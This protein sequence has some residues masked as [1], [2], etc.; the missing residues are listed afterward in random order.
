MTARAIA[1]TDAARRHHPPRCEL[2]ILLPLLALLLL[3]VS[4][5]ARAAKIDAKAQA[6][7]LAVLAKLAPS[8]CPGLETDDE[9]VTA[10]MAKAR[11]SQADLVTRYKTASLAAIRALKTSS[12]RDPEVACAQIIRHLG[13]TGLGLLNETDP[14]V[15]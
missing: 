1:V 15:P 4:E 11:V 2:A 12:D 13:A 7:Q 3:T 5:P 10:F 8:A 9:A 6:A 14:S